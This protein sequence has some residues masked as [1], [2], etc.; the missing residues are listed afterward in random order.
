MPG[1]GIAQGESVSAGVE[2]GDLDPYQL[3]DDGIDGALPR[4]RSAERGER[5]EHAGIPG[6]GARARRGAGLALRLLAQ[7]PDLVV[8]LVESERVNSRHDRLLLRLEIAA[9]SPAAQRRHGLRDRRRSIS[10]I[11]GALPHGGVLHRARE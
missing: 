2:A 10:T 4:E 9:P 5:L 3:T 8:D 6:I 7:M 11:V 1:P